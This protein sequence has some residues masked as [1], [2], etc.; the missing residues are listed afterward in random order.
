MKIYDIKLI[1]EDKKNKNL[2]FY[3]TLHDWPSKNFDTENDLREILKQKSFVDNRIYS[4]LTYYHDCMSV[5]HRIYSGLTYYHDCMN[6]VTYQV[7]FK[8]K[9]FTN[10]DIAFFVFKLKSI[11]IG[12]EI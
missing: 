5:D 12:A 7:S 3:F 2:V 10:S 6:Y 9:K 1:E 8:L 11:L 4:G